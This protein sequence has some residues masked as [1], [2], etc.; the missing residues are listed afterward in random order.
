[1]SL[2]CRGTSAGIVGGAA[3]LSI[4]Q[5]WPITVPQQLAARLSQLSVTCTVGL[6]LVL[7]CAGQ[8]LCLYASSGSSLSTMADS[9][10]PLALCEPCI[11]ALSVITV[12]SATLCLP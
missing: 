4:C 2:V 8:H 3:L 6:L 1:M 5:Q 12:V 11:S 7:L 9:L 10:F